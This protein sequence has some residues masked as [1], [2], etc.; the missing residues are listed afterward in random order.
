MS[1][2]WASH[3]QEEQGKRARVDEQRNDQVV[4]CVTGSRNALGGISVACLQRLQL[5]HVEA[6]AVAMVS[7]LLMKKSCF[8]C[9]FCHM[10]LT[11]RRGN[12]PAANRALSP[13]L[14]IRYPE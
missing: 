11:I 2:I 3:V 5:A 10:M 6:Q 12:K 14:F 8:E 7:N 9:R 1:G 13:A 4:C